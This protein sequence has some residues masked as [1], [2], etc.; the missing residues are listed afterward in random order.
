LGRSKFRGLN[1]VVLSDFKVKKLRIDDSEAFLLY[2]EVGDDLFSFR[3]FSVL[4]VLLKKIKEG[5]LIFSSQRIVSLS[6]KF[7]NILF[8][9]FEE[10]ET[11]SH[12]GGDVV[13][14]ISENNTGT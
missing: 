8:S 12:S 4:K 3:V 10:E 14:E 7:F 13:A 5:K 6:L 2:F 9:V 1:F 11:T